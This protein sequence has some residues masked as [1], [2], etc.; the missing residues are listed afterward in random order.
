MRLG[1]EGKPKQNNR[2]CRTKSRLSEHL[3]VFS[4]Q[5]EVSRNQQEKSFQKA[6]ELAQEKQISLYLSIDNTV[7]E[8]ERPFSWPCSPWREQAGTILIWRVNRYSV[9]YL[10]PISARMILPCAIVCAAA[11]R[12]AAPRS[13][14][15][16]NFWKHLLKT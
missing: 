2:F 1:Y 15:R 11:V 10:A 13:R 3:R 6:V 7:I 16:S 12:K 14:W 8:E 5:R 9:R 4:F